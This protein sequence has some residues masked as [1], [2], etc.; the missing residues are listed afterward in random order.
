MGSALP[1]TRPEA[2]QTS[3]TGQVI[4]MNRTKARRGRGLTDH[5][6]RLEDARRATPTDA[7]RLARQHL[8]RAV[9]ERI[10]EAQRAMERY[11]SN[12]GSGYNGRTLTT[13]IQTG[14]LK[15]SI[16]DRIEAGIEAI[17]ASGQRDLARGFRAEVADWVARHDKFAAD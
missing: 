1:G 9:D 10:S 7:L 16:I 8:S 17:H 11:Q 4:Q 2:Q 14:C 3:K 5:E 13:Y 12:P 6:M 15:G